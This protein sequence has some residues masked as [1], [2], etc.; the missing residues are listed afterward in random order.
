MFSNFAA[1]FASLWSLTSA[2]DIGNKLDVDVVE[3][4]NKWFA[5]TLI[6]ARNGSPAFGN[7]GAG[8]RAEFR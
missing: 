7:V 6:L 3:T 8:N 1:I 5:G 2:N 4:S